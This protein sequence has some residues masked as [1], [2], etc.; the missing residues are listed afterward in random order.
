[1]IGCHLIYQSR[2]TIRETADYNTPPAYASVC[3]YV[4]V[5]VCVCVCV[6]MIYL[7]TAVGL[8]PGGNSTVHI[9]TQTIQRTTPL[10][11]RTTQLTT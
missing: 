1:M 5:F 10:T 3:M 11:T 9:Y 6:C 2:R 4:C 7:L 8:T